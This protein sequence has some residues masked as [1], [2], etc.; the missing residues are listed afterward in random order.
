MNGEMKPTFN[1]CEQFQGTTFVMM[2]ESMRK[3]LSQFIH[4]VEDAES[5][6]RAFGLA[7]Y[8]PKKSTDLR[9]KKLEFKDGDP[10]PNIKKEDRYREDYCETNIIKKKRL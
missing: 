4:E 7:L 6:V 10:Y 3:L 1:V 9:R 8:N 5:E 2:N